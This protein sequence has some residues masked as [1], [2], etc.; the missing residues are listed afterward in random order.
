MRFYNHIRVYIIYRI[1]V[2]D[3]S[4]IYDDILVITM[5]R[6]HVLQYNFSYKFVT[7]DV[8]IKSV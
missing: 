1:N 8:Q 6:D 3:H 2:T 4:I 5:A 7:P